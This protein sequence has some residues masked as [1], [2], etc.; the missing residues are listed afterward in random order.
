MQGLYGTELNAAV[1]FAVPHAAGRILDVGCG[2]GMLGQFI[3]KRQC[4]ELVGI[5]NNALAAIHARQYYDVVRELDIEHDE[6]GQLGRFDCIICSHILEHVVH[7]QQVLQQMADFLTPDGVIVVALPNVASWKSRWAI[8]RGRGLPS[9]GGVFDRTHRW[10]FNLRTSKKLVT[11]AGL[12]IGHITADGNFPLP[13]MRRLF[14][15]L[16]RCIDR[17]VCKIWPDMFSCQFVIIVKK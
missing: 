8:V 6:L 7:P 12:T 16:A 5:E 2:V 3:K 17:T 4:C 9:D 1:L 11:D 10:F 15:V 13:Y 14:P